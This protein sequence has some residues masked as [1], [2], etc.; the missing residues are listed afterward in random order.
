MGQTEKEMK[1]T[2]WKDRPPSKWDYYLQRE[3]ERRYKELE[4]SK[5]IKTKRKPIWIIFLVLSL[6][7]GFLVLFR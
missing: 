7:M 3:H 4:F 5:E 6:M 2:A 1:H